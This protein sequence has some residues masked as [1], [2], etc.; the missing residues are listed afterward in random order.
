[1]ET[2]GCNIR[3]YRDKNKTVSCLMEYVYANLS[4]VA[5][6]TEF[7]YPTL[8]AA[9]LVSG[10][11]GTGLFLE[12][13]VFSNICDRLVTISLF[14]TLASAVIYRFSKVTGALLRFSNKPSLSRSISVL[15]VKAYFAA[16]TLSAIAFSVLDNPQVKQ[17]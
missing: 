13:T 12:H 16:I 1:M 10:A 2:L 5:L 4:V 9:G 11:G 15:L 7:I 8:Y 17:S 14:I 3:D 6:Q